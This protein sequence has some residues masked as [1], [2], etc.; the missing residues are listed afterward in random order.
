MRFDLSFPLRVARKTLSTGRRQTV[1]ASYRTIRK[2]TA[3]FTVLAASIVLASCGGGGDDQNGPTRSGDILAT[4]AQV[5]AHVQ[6]SNIGF[7]PGIH[8]RPAGTW[9]WQGTPAQHVLVHIPAPGSGNDTEP[10]LADKARRAVELINR[11]LAGLLVLQAVDVMPDSGNHIR[12]RYG[13]SYVPP[14][15]TNYAS[16]CANVSTGPNVGNMIVP[17]RENGIG[18]NPVY[19][20][21]GNGRC[22]VTQDIVTH[23]FGH[24]LGLAY[25][26]EGFGDGPPV[27]TAFWDVLATLYGNPVSAAATALVVVRASP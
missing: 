9:R 15:S 18:S 3:A 4:D 1:Q 23:E 13:T 11:R 10:D 14:G 8:G 12:V 16:Y 6:R 24:A 21:L 5:V 27:S 17:D 26:F 2:T 19:V 20:N 25:H 7:S 22:N